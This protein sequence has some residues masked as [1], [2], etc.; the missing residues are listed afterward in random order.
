MFKDIQESEKKIMHKDYLDANFT[1]NYSFK[2]EKENFNENKLIKFVKLMEE[3]TDD[4][5]YIYYL[6]YEKDQFGIS[7]HNTRIILED[8]NNLETCILN[9]LNNRIKVIYLSKSKSETYDNA[10]RIKQSN[11]Y[12]YISL[13]PKFQQNPQLFYDFFTKLKWFIDNNIMPFRCL[14]YGN[15]ASRFCR[16][17]IGELYKKTGK[18]EYRDFANSHF[19]IASGDNWSLLKPKYNENYQSFYKTKPFGN[20]PLFPFPDYTYLEGLPYHK[21]THFDNGSA[22]LQIVEDICLWDEDKEYNE[23]ML[24]FIDAY[25]ERRDKYFYSLPIE[26]QERMLKELEPISNPSPYK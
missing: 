9:I 5:E 2:F 24:K 1:I 15:L 22:W 18:L 26:E 6:K 7:F 14:Y 10:I 8:Y 19:N 13:M 4:K 16:K 23:A 12:I 20:L 17:T 11:D 25:I 3:I 21:L